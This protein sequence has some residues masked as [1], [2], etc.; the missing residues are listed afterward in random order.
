MGLKIKQDDRCLDSHKGKTSKTGLE[1][2]WILQQKKGGVKDPY[3]DRNE[4]S[5]VKF[6]SSGTR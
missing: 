3:S 1:F 2:G 6:K 5:R 4:E